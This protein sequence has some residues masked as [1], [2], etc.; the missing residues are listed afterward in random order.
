MNDPIPHDL[1]LQLP[2]PPGT[3]KFL[4]VLLFLVHILFVN[5]MV[6][7]H[8]LAL[9]F[10]L[11]GLKKQ[12]Y[13]KLAK[14]ISKTITVNKSLAVVLGVAPLL[15]INLAYTTYF[16]SA[17]SLT[18]IAWVMVIPLVTLAFLL[19][20]LYSYSWQ[21]WQGE[22]KTLHII[23]GVMA[24]I[25]FW[26]IPLIFLA[27][28]NLMLFPSRW[29]TVSGFLSA[30]SLP[31]VLPRYFHFL[32]ATIAVTALFAVPWFGRKTFDLASR[33]PGFERNE[34]KRLFYRIA[35]FVTLFQF[36]AGPLLLFTLPVQG[37]S[38]ELYG[39]ILIGVISAITFMI[40]IWNEIRPANPRVGRLFGLIVVLLTSTVVAMAYG[41]HIYR[42]RA[43]QPHHEA[44]ME[45]T[46]EFYWASEAA[47]AR[48]RMGVSKQTFT[49]GGEMAFEQNCSVCH[50]MDVTLVGPPLTEIY[51]IYENDVQ[52]IVTWSREP[53]VKRGGTPM[54]AFK[55]LGDE[56]LTEISEYMLNLVGAK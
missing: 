2:L 41:R 17:T 16:Y 3:L 45:R 21:R 6:G 36:M 38:W 48:T 46:Q 56:T 1:G 54:P 35:F 23:V 55:H 39:V 9:L 31:N 52:G 12:K 19:T 18:G 42:D 13:D 4:L 29:L 28:V 32:L 15:V 26:T 44:M 25:L 30:L 50:A 33:L 20:Y 10:E 22:H 53:G 11:V 51:E 40:L 37:I 7:G 47:R 24:A 14:E 34:I 5:F 49:S 43:I 27:N 8:T